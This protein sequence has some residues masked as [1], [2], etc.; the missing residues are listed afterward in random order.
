MTTNRPSRKRT[1]FSLTPQ[2]LFELKKLNTNIS[3]TV[4]PR[5]PSRA[6]GSY[7]EY[8]FDLGVYDRY[9]DLHE[10]AKC[11]RSIWLR[12]HRITRAVAADATRTGYRPFVNAGRLSDDAPPP[13]PEG[14]EQAW[15]TVFAPKPKPSAPAGAVFVDV[16][17]NGMR[18]FSF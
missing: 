13:M 2:E 7:S 9:R 3:A 6:G 11:E 8:A 1:V 15:Q 12:E 5:K 18:G 14:Y 17:S 10:R 4:P 16:L